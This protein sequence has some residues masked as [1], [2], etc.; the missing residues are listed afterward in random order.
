M[1]SLRDFWHLPLAA[2]KY[3][4]FVYAGQCVYAH[5]LDLGRSRNRVRLRAH[6]ARLPTKTTRVCLQSLGRKVL[7]IILH[8]ALRGYNWSSTHYRTSFAS[9]GARWR[10]VLRS[11]NNY[12]F[13]SSSFIDA[14]RCHCPVIFFV[15]NNTRFQLLFT[16]ITCYNFLRY[17][18][19][20][21][22]KHHT[23]LNH[24]YRHRLNS[25]FSSI[26]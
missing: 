5:P 3:F 16:W 9:F 19:A 22:I 13:F 4:F 21:L 1:K 24:Y 14:H 25:Y 15:C 7:R 12:N 23:V 11:E 26:L 10:C 17:V 20:L 6:S 8:A 18:F 2:Y